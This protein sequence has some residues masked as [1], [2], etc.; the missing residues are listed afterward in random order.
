MAD[1]D[2]AMKALEMTATTVLSLNLSLGEMVRPEDG[3]IGRQTLSAAVA[4]G[5]I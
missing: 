2:M 1:K 3:R 4:S 5:R